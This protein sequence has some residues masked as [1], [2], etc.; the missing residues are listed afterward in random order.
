MTCR[1]SDGRPRAA[2][3]CGK[4]CRPRKRP[5]RTTVR[6][7]FPAGGGYRIRSYPVRLPVR[8]GK[9]L[10]GN[11]ISTCDPC[12]RRPVWPGR[13]C[14]WARAS[15]W[16]TASVVSRRVA[17]NAAFCTAMMLTRGAPE[18]RCAPRA[19]GGPA[20]DYSS[21]GTPR[22]R[23]HCIARQAFNTYRCRHPCTQS[24]RWRRCADTYRRSAH[25]HVFAQVFGHVLS[26]EGQ[27]GQLQ[28]VSQ[29]HCSPK[30]VPLASASS[31][32]VLNDSTC[33]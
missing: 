9:P 30:T 33:G 24:A 25:A 31:G 17:M 20:S 13:R 3:G 27:P 23:T 12:R 5:E 14:P 8:G 21:G 26:Q 22:S 11:D 6:R 28:T 2:A 15:Q 29:L 32:V 18:I 10:T 1:T 7:G 4:N 19:V 16:P